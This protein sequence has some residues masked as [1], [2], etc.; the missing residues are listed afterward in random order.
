MS[1]IIK[2][3]T[4]TKNKNLET[5]MQ[6]TRHMRPALQLHAPQGSGLGKGVY[7]REIGI[8]SNMT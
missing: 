1:K 3:I 7:N 4:L 6:F 8:L 2:Y 5:M